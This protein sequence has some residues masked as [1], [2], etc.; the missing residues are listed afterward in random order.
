MLSFLLFLKFSLESD[1]TAKCEFVP[2]YYSA[3]LLSEV[4]LEKSK[5]CN[6]H[7]LF[8]NAVT[9]LLCNN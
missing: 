5:K 2:N 9:I 6:S 1:E 3:K 8:D 4:A 7:V